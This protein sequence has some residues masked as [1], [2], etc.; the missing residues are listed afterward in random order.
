MSIP[1][2][3][4]SPNDRILQGSLETLY[5]ISRH[6]SRSSKPVAALNC[7]QPHRSDTPLSFALD[8]HAVS[9]TFSSDRCISSLPRD[10]TQFSLAATRGA[11]TSWK[12]EPRGNAT[13]FRVECGVQVFFLAF[14]KVDA[15][16]SDYTLWSRSTGALRALPYDDYHVVAVLLRPGSKMYVFLTALAYVTGSYHLP[17]R[18]IPPHTLYAFHTLEHSI[19]SGG[20]FISTVT[21]TASVLGCFHTFF[22]GDIIANADQPTFST[23]MNSIAAWY[24]ES[25]INGPTTQHGQSPPSR[26]TC[27][28]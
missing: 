19:C 13:W 17:H 25:I 1:F 18:I 28:S 7:P 16:C 21:L 2:R 26:K 6:D 24:Y 11:L 23:R 3:K 4:D 15:L 12:V 27:H 20:H 10:D 22:V 5:T 9:R 8:A 14:P